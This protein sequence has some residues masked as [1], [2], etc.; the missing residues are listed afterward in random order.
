MAT[1]LMTITTGCQ[2]AHQKALSIARDRVTKLLPLSH[3]TSTT[4]EVEAK[5]TQ[6]ALARFG[7]MYPGEVEKVPLSAWKFNWRQWESRCEIVP[8]KEFAKSPVI[9]AQKGFMEATFCLLAQIF[10]VNSPFD[11]LRY[12]PEDVQMDKA[13]VRIG[14]KKNPE[15]GIYL[16]D[17][18]FTVTSK[19]PRG[20]FFAHYA[21]INGEW[22]PDRMEHQPENMKILLSDIQ[23]DGRV[24]GRRMIKSMELSVGTEQAFNHSELIVKNCRH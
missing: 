24:S 20:D 2:T 3:Y 14:D 7:Q 9:Q 6:P 10:Y 17:K 8:P 5:P 13:Q 11:D 16:A 23:Y 15:Q 21:K 22:L 12:G 1:L 19:T 4:C 18:D